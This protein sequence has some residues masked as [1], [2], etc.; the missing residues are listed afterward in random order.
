MRSRAGSKS[1]AA[2]DHRR[3][4]RPLRFLERRFQVEAQCLY[5]RLDQVN[6]APHNRQEVA[7]LPV[8]L[9][10]TCRDSRDIEKILDDTR[11][12]SGISLDHVETFLQVFVIRPGYA[13]LV[14][15]AEN[16]C[17]RCPEFVGYNR[18]ELVLET[19]RL[20]LLGR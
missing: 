14:N 9:E 12:R 6:R 13:K 3:P 1:P 7:L 5:R 16:R 11:L 17:K 18:Q 10:F 20:L 15:G 8:K 19:A 4:N 2:S